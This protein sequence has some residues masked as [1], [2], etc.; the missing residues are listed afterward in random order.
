MGGRNLG[1]GRMMLVMS[2]TVIASLG[3][4]KRGYSGRHTSDVTFFEL[5]RVHRSFAI[6]VPLQLFVVQVC[7]S[8]F[9]F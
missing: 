9:D 8:N 7:N 2:P 6:S 3:H 1:S 4:L 5:R